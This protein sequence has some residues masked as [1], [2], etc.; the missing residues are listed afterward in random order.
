MGRIAL[1]LALLTALV[2]SACSD[3][4]PQETTTSESTTQE[5]SEETPDG[6]ELQSSENDAESES[7]TEPGPTATERSPGESVC[8]AVAAIESP[9]LVFE[10]SLSG[11]V[12]QNLVYLTDNRARVDEL[13]TTL[14]SLS[15][16]FTSDE[17]RQFLTLDLDVLF[18]QRAMD[19]WQRSLEAYESGDL[20]YDGFDVD[21]FGARVVEQ[22]LTV[23]DSCP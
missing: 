5:S 21:E 2:I 11:D 22:V 15:D 18:L 8:A 6:D 10:V 13:A 16:S 4:S 7:N 19:R 20:D 3:S 17:R 12:E 9:P 1:V 14:D 23:R